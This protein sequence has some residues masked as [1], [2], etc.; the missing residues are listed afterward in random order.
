ATKSVS[1]TV[2]GVAKGQ[3]FVASVNE[4]IFTYFSEYAHLSTPEKNQITIENLLNMRSSFSW[5]EMLL[6]YS[7]PDNDAILLRTVDDPLQHVLGKDLAGGPGTS[8]SYNSGNTILLGEIVKR[9]TGLALDVFCVD[10]LFIPLGIY[11]YEWNFLHNNIVFASSDLKLRPRDMA[12]IGNLFCHWKENGIVPEAW[13]EESSKGTVALPA[14]WGADAYGYQWWAQD[15]Q[16]GS[17]VIS[18]FSARGFGGQRIEVFPNLDMLVILTG[19]NYIQGG[20]DSDLL[21]SYILPAAL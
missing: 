17:Q 15:Y 18:S 10:H 3:G 4:H 8:F 2:L 21:T 11:D 14:V 1:A 16:I 20:K 5:N 13:I 6:P 12:K 19:A 9:A 7:D